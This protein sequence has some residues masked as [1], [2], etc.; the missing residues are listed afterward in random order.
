MPHDKSS[1]AHSRPEDYNSLDGL[2]APVPAGDHHRENCSQDGN[3]K[4]DSNNGHLFS[5]NY[6]TPDD[7]TNLNE[8]ASPS[9]VQNPHE[10][11]I[12]REEYLEECRS[13]EQDHPDSA[14][15]EINDNQSVADSIDRQSAVEESETNTADRR[16]PRASK[17]ATEF[18]TVSYLISFS[19]LGCL[20]R[21]GL[22]ALTEYPGSPVATSVLWANVG[23]CIIMGYLSED[24]S[25]FKA[26]RRMEEKEREEEKRDNSDGSENTLGMTDQ[27]STPENED[28]ERGRIEDQEAHNATKKTIPLY[29]GLT[30]GFCGSF[31]SF[32]SF[33]RDVFLELANQPQAVHSSSASDSALPRNGGYSFMAV[34]AVIVLTVGLC[35]SALKFGA[36][37]AIGLENLTPSLPPFLTRKTFDRCAALFSWGL[38]LASILLV[39]WPPDRPLG[40]AAHPGMSWGQETW[41]GEVLFSL[42]FAPVGC[43]LRFYASLRLNGIMGSFPLGTFIVNI[44]GTAILGMCW[45]LQR[46]PLGAASGS[47]GG[48]RVGC[49]VLQG[50]QDG[51]CGC[52]TTISTWALELTSLRRKHAYTYAGIS[53]SVGLAFLVAIM[54]SLIWSRGIS[55]VAC[56]S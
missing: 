44:S 5:N 55:P 54:G 27:A 18:Y 22:Q 21:L 47:I 20:A 36:H 37:L 56:F 19:I 26:H 10:R 2:A 7:F 32:S 4:F 45:N 41:R 53:V 35:L 12:Y 15:R 43:I 31:T 13:Q 46:A 14:T 29:I 24:R 38:W 33:I 8:L 50:V 34:V 39:I 42:V 1:E 11:H 40:P 17:F 49:Q 52:L 25:L 51:L 9:P 16:G 28:P 30:T 6:D 3:R 23:G 48:G